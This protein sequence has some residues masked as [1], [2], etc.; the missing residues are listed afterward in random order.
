MEGGERMKL[1]RE[2]RITYLEGSPVNEPPL[3]EIAIV[4]AGLLRVPDIGTNGSDHVTE[5][6]LRSPER[7]FT[8]GPVGNY[9]CCYQVFL[10]MGPIAPMLHSQPSG[11]PISPSSNRHS[12]TAASPFDRSSYGLRQNTHRVAIL[13][14]RKPLNRPSATFKISQAVEWI[15]AK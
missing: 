1:R 12:R 5:F 9:Y 13:V 15:S 2:E 3:Q 14:P 4:I 11:M 6:V 8:N 10:P 7:V